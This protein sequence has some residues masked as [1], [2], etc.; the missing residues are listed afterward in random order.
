[1]TSIERTAYPQ[2]K[3]LVSARVLHVS[4]TPAPDEIS[5]A[6]ERTSGAEPLLAVVLALKCYQKMARFPSADEVPEVVVEHVRRCLELGADVEPDHGAGRTA[7]WHRKQIRLRQGASYDP[8]RARRIAA[9][10]IRETARARNNPPDLI[11]VALERLVEASLELPGFS[12]LDEMAA[13]IRAEVNS[14]IFAEICQRAGEQGRA[15]LEA[16]IA[17]GED[18]L[19][20][21]HRLKKPAKR[22]SWSRFKAQADYM[23]EVDVI[24][25]T[26]AWLEGG[27][28]SKI[29]DFAG[30]A[31]AQ[32]VDTLSRY[33]EVKRM[34]LVAC[35]VHTARMRA[36]DDLAEMLCKRVAANV[37][38]G[39]EDELPAATPAALPGWLSPPG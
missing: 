11:N 7:K 27:A 33:G 26:D 5:W 16:L 13:T 22:A 18:R 15:R 17:V 31:A 19:S 20:M 9:A 32:D 12:T 8:P 34:A 10:A 6:R 1:M 35:L 14:E 2:F 30:E 21:F 4:F 39:A 38:L 37:K 24:G 36:R 25:D 28:P 29:A 23:A 3:K